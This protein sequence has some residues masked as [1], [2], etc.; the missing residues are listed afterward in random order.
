MSIESLFS[1]RF[2]TLSSRRQKK[3]VQ[4][5]DVYY[6][7]I[8]IYI[9]I[10]EKLNLYTINIYVSNSFNVHPSP[11]FNFTQ[12]PQKPGPPFTPTVP[13]WHFCA[14]FWPSPS[15][16]SPDVGW[17]TWQKNPPRCSVLNTRWNGTILW[18]DMVFIRQWIGKK[19]SRNL[20]RWWN[21]HEKHML[22][23]VKVLDLSFMQWPEV[24]SSQSLGCL[25]I[26]KSRFTLVEA[27]S[28]TPEG[29]WM[30]MHATWSFCWTS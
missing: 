3:K 16:W 27:E 6:L 20:S 30:K 12:P 13:T 9:A 5:D 7:Q 11:T 10:C 29:K 24:I 18:G 22:G 4:N 23:S 15:F 28:Q 26:L 8:S 19:N 25:M 14:T 1:K 2:W 17:K 21:F